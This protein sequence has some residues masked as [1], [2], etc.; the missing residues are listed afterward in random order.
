MVNDASK[1]ANKADYIICCFFDLEVLASF[2][3]TAC[4]VFFFCLFFC[5]NIV[6]IVYHF[7]VHSHVQTSKKHLIKIKHKYL[8][9]SV[10]SV[11]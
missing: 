9:Y 10:V 6:L 3:T 5:L 8:I 2:D 1:M 4:S 7:E 11:T